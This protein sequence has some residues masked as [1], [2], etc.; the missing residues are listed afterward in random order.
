MSSTSR[1]YGSR[2]S[3]RCSVCYCEQRYCS[4]NNN[5]NNNNILRVVFVCVFFRI[6]LFHLHKAGSRLFTLQGVRHHTWNDDE[7]FDI[8]FEVG[9]RALERTINAGLLCINS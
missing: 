9:N 4:Y 3:F 5:K 1:Y 8:I 6:F 2:L 7:F